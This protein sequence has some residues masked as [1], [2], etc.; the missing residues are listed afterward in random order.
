MAKKR[1]AYSYFNAQVIERLKSKI[2]TA[3]RRLERTQ[4]G[5]TLFAVLTKDLD[6]L[7]S[8]LALVR[9]Q[10]KAYWANKLQCDPEKLNV[11]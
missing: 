6:T 11:P 8:E 1:T 7:D 4:R 10:Y 2:L 3:E 5:T 9:K